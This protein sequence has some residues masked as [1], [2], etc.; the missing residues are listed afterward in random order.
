MWDMPD[1]QQATQ[2]NFE[3]FKELKEFLKY[4]KK[5]RTEVVS[6]SMEPLIMTGDSVY[7]EPVQDIGELKRFDIILFLYNKILVCHVIWHLNHLPNAEGE[8]V[9]ITR[10]IRSK[11]DDLPVPYSHVLGIVKEPRLSLYWKLR[12]TFK[13]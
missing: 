11:Y 8:R 3:Q 7:V 6:G 1:S 4:Q 10:G 5:I 12:M 13:I 2:L 9:F